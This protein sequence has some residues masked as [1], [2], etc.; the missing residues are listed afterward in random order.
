MYQGLRVQPRRLGQVSDRGNRGCEGVGQ[1]R[2]P[3]PLL[4]APPRTPPPRAF[5][6]FLLCLLDSVTPHA[7]AQGLSFS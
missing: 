4:L 5:A 3:P 2:A 1:T 7:G 6:C